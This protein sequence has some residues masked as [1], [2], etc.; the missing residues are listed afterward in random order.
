[1][2]IKLRA[3][4]CA[5]LLS[6]G[7]A[8][9]SEATVKREME[10]KYPGVPVH[11]VAKTPMPGI[12]EVFVNG[13]IVYT[14][15][16]VTYLIVRGRMIDVARRADVTEERMRVLTATK[17]DEIPFE[18]AFRKV[19]GKGTRKLAYFA[20]PNCPYCKK[21][22]AEFAKLED[23][24][25]YIFLYPV[26]GQDSHEKAKAVW[27][28]ENRVKAWD[29][30]M[31]NGKAPDTPATCDTPIEKILAFGQRQA[32]TGTPTLFFA[33]GQRVTGAIPA[34]QLRELLDAAR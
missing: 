23:V 2:L 11:S 26:L 14:D 27:C 19:Q 15:E 18:L 6:S 12:Y 1:M 3:C 8:A 10:K 22:E 21:I 25:I 29:D 24:T 5:A 4:L 9:A 13:Q 17:F 31:L 20:D 7:M 33:D 28:S 30:M 16:N 32:I 34:D